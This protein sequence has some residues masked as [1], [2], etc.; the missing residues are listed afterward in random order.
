[1]PETRIHSLCLTLAI[2]LTLSAEPAT[3]SR[4]KSFDF[5][6]AV[7]TDVNDINNKNTAVGYCL[8]QSGIA[9]GFAFIP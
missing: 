8:N 9:H 1:V 4:F 6:G 3:A 7:E 2:T 5:P